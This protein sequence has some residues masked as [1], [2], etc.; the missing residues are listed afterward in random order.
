[1]PVSAAVG[2]ALSM[3]RVVVVGAGILGTMHAWAARRAGADVVHIDR[4]LEAR[5]A[6]V[7]N[8]GLVW[9]GGRRA[10]REL[11]LARRRRGLW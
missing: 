4:D 11:E 5:G 9:V 10:G 1:M 3:R 6:S 2:K 7:R 8:F